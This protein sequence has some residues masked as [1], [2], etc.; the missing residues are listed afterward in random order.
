MSTHSKAESAHL[1]LHNLD[2]Q[3]APQHLIAG[4]GAAG[5][6]AQRVQQT[7]GVALE[8]LGGNYQVSR[9][10]LGVPALQPPQAYGSQAAG[11]QAQLGS[12]LQPG[13]QVA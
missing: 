7:L 11:S 4:L 8:L 5:C 9:G 10:F 1:S 6:C 3:L 12:Y 13:W 2:H